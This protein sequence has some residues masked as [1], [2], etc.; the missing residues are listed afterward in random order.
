M[1]T[2]KEVPWFADYRAGMAMNTSLPDFPSDVELR[3]AFSESAECWDTV[4]DVRGH[5]EGC[6]F[7]GVRVQMNGECNEDGCGGG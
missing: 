1:T 5:F 6:G 7:E 3:S 4:E 2:W